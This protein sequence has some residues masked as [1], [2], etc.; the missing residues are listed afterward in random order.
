MGRQRKRR[1]CL[2]GPDGRTLVVIGMQSRGTEH[3]PAGATLDHGFQRLIAD[4]IAWR[5]VGQQHVVA[6]RAHPGAIQ[7]VEQVRVP[8]PAPRP[9]AFVASAEIFDRTLVDFDHDDATGRLRFERTPLHHAIEDCILGRVERA[10]VAPVPGKPGD[11][12]KREQ[13]IERELQPQRD[14]RKRPP[15]AALDL[16][17]REDEA[18]AECRQAC[19]DPRK[20]AVRQP[21]DHRRSPC[22]IMAG[23]Q[24]AGLD[25]RASATAPVIACSQAVR[26][27]LALAAWVAIASINGGDRQ[28]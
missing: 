27:P 25:H 21:A 16:G 19:V 9:A 3:E 12:A 5:G 15:V 22:Q 14:L 20:H 11:R 4:R 7:L 28:S 24:A 8:L 18:V 1:R 13:R 10:G 26:T 2:R 17:P 6:D 23:W